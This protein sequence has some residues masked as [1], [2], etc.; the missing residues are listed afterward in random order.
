LCEI[1]PAVREIFAITKMD[2]IL[3][4][5]DT[6]ERALAAVNEPAEPPPSE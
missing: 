1:C 2:T 3:D 6:E 4:I 5:V